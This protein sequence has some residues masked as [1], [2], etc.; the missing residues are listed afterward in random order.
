MKTTSYKLGEC[1]IIESDDR[2]L[3]SKAHF[4]LGEIKDGRCF[5]KG[6]SFSWDRRKAAATVFFE[7]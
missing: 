7:I 3:R 4:G 1:K 5:K 6:R 2:Y